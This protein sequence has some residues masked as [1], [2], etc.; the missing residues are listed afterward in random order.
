MTDEQIRCGDIA[1]VEPC[2]SELKEGDIIMLALNGMATLRR[3]TLRGAITYF[4]GNQHEQSPLLPAWEHAFSGV[5]TAVFRTY[6][7]GRLLH[8]S[9]EADEKPKGRP[10]KSPKQRGD[11]K[12]ITCCG[13]R[14]RDDPPEA[15]E[16][17]WRAH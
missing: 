11:K 9:R 16:S 5:V 8:R 3:V 7:H 1:I 2:V 12:Q 6:Y 4:Q 10:K 15:D 17:N 13:N 14:L